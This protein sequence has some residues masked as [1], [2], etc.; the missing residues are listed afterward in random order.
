MG[1]LYRESARAR[2]DACAAHA[3]GLESPP[4]V[5]S[6]I[7]PRD[8]KERLEGWV[9]GDPDE[10]PAAKPRPEFP[11][12]EP[13]RRERRTRARREKHHVPDTL[14]RRGVRTLKR[15]L[16]FTVWLA[17]FAAGLAGE[18][19][20]VGGILRDGDYGDATVTLEL[21]QRSNWHQAAFRPLMPGRYFV[22]LVSHDTE[23]RADEETFTGRVYVRVSD[24]DGRALIAQRFEPPGLDHRLRGGV[25]WTP[26]T[27]LRVAR[28][29]VDPWTISARTGRGDPQF[30]GIASSVVL[31][32]DRDTPG[33]SGLLNY[34]VVAPAAVALALSLAAAIA[35]PRNGG[36]WMPALLSVVSLAGLA[37]A[38]AAV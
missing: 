11:E 29:S 19:L 5:A 35:V 2:K 6:L 28:P 21:A 3:G 1:L 33:I 15:T 34:A 27:Q 10:P 30:D 37:F 7:R 13:A 20:F 16:A 32:R 24:P 12:R 26:V 17:L 14:G 22:Y 9:L 18:A 38:Y 23:A 36:T 25:E 8:E 4:L 31:V